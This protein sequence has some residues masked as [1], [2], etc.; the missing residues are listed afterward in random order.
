LKSSTQMS[1][2]TNGDRDIL[3]EVPRDLLNHVTPPSLK[4]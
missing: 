2:E 1:G 3:V 4:H